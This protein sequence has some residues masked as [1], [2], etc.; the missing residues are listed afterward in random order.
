[1]NELPPRRLSV[2]LPLAIGALGAPA[3]AQARLHVP[4]QFA[5]IGAAVQAA[6]PGTIIE[7]QQGIYLPF[8]IDRELT[9]VGHAVDG[10]APVVEVPRYPLA[11]TWV[12]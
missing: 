3:I 10:Q 5:Q 11:G 8:V 7:V 6:A 2:L 1:M 4:T 9:I 12:P